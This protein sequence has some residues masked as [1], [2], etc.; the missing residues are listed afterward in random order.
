MIGCPL[1]SNILFC[2]ALESEKSTGG[3]CPFGLA[4]FGSNRSF[5]KSKPL[6]TRFLNVIFGFSPRNILR[7]HQ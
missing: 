7:L 1:D 2:D 3:L 5:H 6:A 4:F